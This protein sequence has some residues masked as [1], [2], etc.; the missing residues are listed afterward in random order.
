[1]KWKKV[2]QIFDPTHLTDRPGWMDSFAQAPNALIFDDFVRVYFCCR[3]R[4]DENNQFVSYCAYADLDRKDLRKVKRVAK[5]PILSLG[6]LGAFDEFGTYPVSIARDGEDIIAIYGGW[7][8]C[9]SVP[10]NISL[11]YA[12]SSDGG[13]TFERSGL[14]PILSHSVN[15]PFVVTSPKIR[16]FNNSWVLAYTAGRKWFYDKDGNPE[17]IYK[18]RIA[19]SDDGVNWKKLDRD[20][21]PNSIG[22]DEAQA[23]PDI[24]QVGGKY[25]MFFCYRHALDFRTNSSRSYRLGYASSTDLLDWK[26]DDTQIELDVTP[27][28]WDADMIAYPHVFELDG[29]IYMLY[30]GNGNGKTGFGLAVL[31]DNLPK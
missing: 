20:L 14:G 16:S 23:C 31:E 22:V 1:M 28:S 9:E 8:R 26:R 15:E 21:I 25:H 5:S 17:I 11:G 18:L 30:G 4:P 19:F 2:G 10:F 3:P 13:V 24:I 6:G 7:T 12:R 29:I 27:G